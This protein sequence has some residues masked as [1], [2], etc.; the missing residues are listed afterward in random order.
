M[1]FDVSTF[2][3]TTRDNSNY[4]G[5]AAGTLCEVVEPHDGPVDGYVR[6]RAQE[7]TRDLWVYE[8]DVTALDPATITDPDLYKRLVVRMVYKAQKENEWCGEAQNL[9]RA[10]GLEDYMPQTRTVVVT[11]HVTVQQWPGATE[12][13]VR[14]EGQRLA[15]QGQ[16]WVDSVTLA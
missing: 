6:V 10:A 3:T 7:G 5:I 2:V 14:A 1:T 11:T 8:P 15:A 16:G 9:L 13:S 12:R 4:S